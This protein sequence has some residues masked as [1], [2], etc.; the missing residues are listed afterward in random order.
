MRNKR[1]VLTCYEHGKEIA[2]VGQAI[3]H[4]RA[5][6]VGFI[7]RPG[8]LGQMD[9]HGHY[10]YCFDCRTELKDHRSFDSDEAI[11]SHLKSRHSCAMD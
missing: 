8:R 1:P 7:R 4:L 6:H 2:D 3:E 5:K 9:A 11:W 10:W